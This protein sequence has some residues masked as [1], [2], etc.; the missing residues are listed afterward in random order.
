MIPWR[1]ALC[2]PLE[3]IDS[4]YQIQLPCQARKPVEPSSL[5]GERSLPLGCHLVNSTTPLPGQVRLTDEPAIF[6]PLDR[7]VNGPGSHPESGGLL[8]VP[9]DRVAMFRSL[10]HREQDMENNMRKDLIRNL[11][12]IRM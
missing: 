2:G 1:E 6:H 10:L 12:P 4:G 5:G 8:R 3:R 9:H 11:S 7:T